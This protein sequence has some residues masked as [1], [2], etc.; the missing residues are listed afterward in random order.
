MPAASLTVAGP[1]MT[2]VGVG[3]GAAV[4]SMIPPVPVTPPIVN[5]KVSVGSA[6][7]ESVNVGTITAK[8][9]TPAG[10]VIR[11]VAELNVTPLLKLAF[12]NTLLKSD[13]AVAVTPAKAKE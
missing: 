11:P 10:T 7:T 6:P 12:D 9:V 8:P 5:D 1:V 4:V 13:P 2:R 3:P